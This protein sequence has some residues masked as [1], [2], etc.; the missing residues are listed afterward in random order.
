[1]LR[2]TEETERSPREVPSSATLT[3]SDRTRSGGSRFPEV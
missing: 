2:M 3:S 1:L